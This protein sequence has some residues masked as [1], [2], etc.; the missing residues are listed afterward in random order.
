MLSTPRQ[1]GPTKRIPAA[2][3]NL[4]QRLLPLVRLIALIGYFAPQYDQRLRPFLRRLASDLDD[5]RRGDGD[6]DE[7]GRLLQPSDA[8]RDAD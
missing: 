5:L 2:A 7:L 4:Q 8:R 3:H 1:F 6:H